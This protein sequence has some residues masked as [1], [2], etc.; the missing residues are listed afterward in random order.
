MDRSK[1]LLLNNN[2][3]LSIGIVVLV[4]AA[5]L[6]I[7]DGQ[8]KSASDVKATAND[9]AHY[10]E[11]QKKDSELLGVKIDALTLLVKSS[12]EDKWSA[13]DARSVWKQFKQLNPKLAVPE[14]P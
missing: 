3:Y 8:A 6:W 5:T 4:I 10:K 14:I 2:S 1:P 13:R 9:L 11:L 7:K 12:S